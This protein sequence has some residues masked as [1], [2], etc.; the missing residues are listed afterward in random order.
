[1]NDKYEKFAQDI[2]L[3]SE[4][5]RAWADTEDDG[6]CNLDSMYMHATGFDSKKLIAAAKTVGVRGYDSTHRGQ[7]IV[8]FAN[9]EC[10]QA[11]ARTHMA[12]EL[13]NQMCKLGYKASVW[14]QID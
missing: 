8:F 7:K 9:P 12:E 1:M 11:S 4:F 5:A 3:A 2:S 13:C 14:Y 10:A 6:T